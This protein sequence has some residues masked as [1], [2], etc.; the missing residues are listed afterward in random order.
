MP[1]HAATSGNPDPEARVFLSYS[2]ED[3]AFARQLFE[4][5]EAR[6]VGAWVDWEGIPPS[7]DWWRELCA[8]I[9]S[10]D[11]FLFVMSPASLASKV[12]ADEIDHAVRQHKRLIPVVCRDVERSVE[13]PESLRRI[14]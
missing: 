14:N 1:E 10:V 8:A 2:R 5:L 13:I 6:G 12:C 4:A 9:E 11:A 3:G 7:A